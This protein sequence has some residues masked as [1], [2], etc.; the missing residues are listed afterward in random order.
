MFILKCYLISPMPDSLSNELRS[1]VDYFLNGVNIDSVEAMASWVFSREFVGFASLAEIDIEADDG[2]GQFVTAFEVYLDQNIVEWGSRKIPDD[3]LQFALSSIE[4]GRPFY[5]YFF[6]NTEFSS[7]ED[8][9]NFGDENS[10]KALFSSWA[11]GITFIDEFV[12]FHP[13]D[14]ETGDVKIQG[15]FDESFR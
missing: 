12:Q 15:Q 6:P 2:I 8:I 1:M 11:E 5:S 10:A 13:I 9:G 4:E 7:S 3:P 14:Q